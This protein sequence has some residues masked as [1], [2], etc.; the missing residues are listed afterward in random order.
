MG[1]KGAVVVDESGDDDLAL[2]TAADYSLSED[3]FPELD[4]SDYGDLYNVAQTE[5]Y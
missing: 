4:C 5:Q 2:D 3:E 1:R